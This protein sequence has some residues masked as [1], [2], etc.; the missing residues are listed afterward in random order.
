MEGFDAVIDVPVRWGD[1]DAQGHVNN[2][3][4]TDYLQE[5]RA[6]FLRDGENRHLIGG[7]VVVVGHQV[8]YRRP[9]DFAADPVQVGIGVTDVG[10]SRFRVAYRLEQ[11]G[12]ACVVASSTLCPFDFETQRPR[13]LTA[14]ERAWFDDHLIEAPEFRPLAA[15]H[16]RGRGFE[17]DL[18]VRWSDLDAYG[19][20]NNVKYFDYVQEARIAM[21]TV[22]DPTTARDGREMLWLV[23]RQD[24]DY[25]A[26][27]GSR[28]EPYA[29]LTA[30]VAVGRTSATFAA[31][32]VDP[33]R[34]TANGEPWVT[35]RARTVLVCA[36]LS[37][38]P[39]PLPERTAAL[40]GESLVG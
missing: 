24:V 17:H 15:P 27:M 35:A 2:A 33:E 4:V 3:L 8:E 40:L 5:A 36:D 16:L 18:R 1:L 38:R 34:T 14:D 32:V 6:G 23:V 39:Q 26:Q 28:I 22:L 11:D 13:R 30:P 10:A 21:T 37:G 20:V 25:L 12:Q 31:E 19:H 9:I 29:V 7:G